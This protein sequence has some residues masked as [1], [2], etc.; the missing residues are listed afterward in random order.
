MHQFEMKCLREKTCFTNLF[1]TSIVKYHEFIQ[2]V[3]S[4]LLTWCWC[5]LKT[6]I[7]LICNAN[8]SL[9]FFL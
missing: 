2:F 8:G 7:Q 3:L 4:I 5:Q 1:Y 6:L 9:H